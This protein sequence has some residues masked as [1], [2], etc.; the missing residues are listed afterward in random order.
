M[1]KKTT[2]VNYLRH[3]FAIY[4]PTFT[5]DTG[6]YVI[7]AVVE[8]QDWFVEQ[9]GGCTSVT[10]SGRWKNDAGE[11]VSEPVTIVYAYGNGF[12]IGIL[13]SFAEKMLEQWDQESIAV[14][15]PDSMVLV[16]RKS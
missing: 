3:R 14:E 13:L 6:R 10:G 12:S 9:F 5:K 4:V 16:S 2:K 1:L 11:V 7:N 8:A 15:T